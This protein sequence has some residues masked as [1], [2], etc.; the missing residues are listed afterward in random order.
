MQNR[1]TSQL[2]LNC[3]VPVVD[4]GR[5]PF[6]AALQTIHGHGRGECHSLG[7]VRKSK[8]LREARCKAGIVDEW[9]FERTDLRLYWIQP[10]AEW[11]D[12]GSVVKKESRQPRVKEDATAAANCG[13]SRP[14]RII[15]DAHPGAEIVH[16][17]CL[18][19]RRDLDSAVGIANKEESRRRA[20]NHRRVYPGSIRV[21]PELLDAAVDLLHGDLRLPPK[22]CVQRKPL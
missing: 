22:S 8:P 1:I 16:V 7:D 21:G 20:R 10:Q 5:G 18:P 15:R 19:G 13:L 12:D 9:I 4:R 11:R 3:N 6:D 14:G 2:A 17:A